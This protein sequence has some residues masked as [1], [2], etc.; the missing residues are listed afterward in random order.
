M[1]A[2]TLTA[3]D[4]V[5]SVSHDLSTDKQPALAGMHTL[6]G[7]LPLTAARTAAAVGKQ[8]NRGVPHVGRIRSTRAVPRVF[9]N[10]AQPSQYT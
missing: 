8:K 6:W 1:H 5:T 2:H 10:A 9:E 7:S 3:P 4:S